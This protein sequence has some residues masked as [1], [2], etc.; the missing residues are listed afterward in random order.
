MINYPF[1]PLSSWSLQFS[2]TNGF[3]PVTTYL[4]KGYL[5]PT[6]YISHP[7]MVR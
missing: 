6:L 7:A 5:R 4:E 2:E 1:Q 3:L